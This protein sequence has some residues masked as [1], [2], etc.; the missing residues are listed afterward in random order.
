MRY[1][2]VGLLLMMHVAA[3]STDSPSNIVTTAPQ[4]DIG[5]VAAAPSESGRALNA[6]I[7]ASRIGQCLTSQRVRDWRSKYVI[8]QVRIKGLP[9]V[10]VV[11]NVQVAKVSFRLIGPDGS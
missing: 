2:R 7:H 10:S 11:E 1:K 5:I 8:R 9:R 6:H 4:R 3:C